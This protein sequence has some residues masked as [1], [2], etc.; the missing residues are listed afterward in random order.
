MGI[1]DKLKKNK[2]SRNTEKLKNSKKNF[3]YLDK[4]I[5]LGPKKVDLDSSVTI[6]DMEIRFIQGIK[7]DVDDLVID[8]HGYTIDSRDKAPIFNITGKNITIKNLSFINGYSQFNGGAVLVQEGASCKFE[9]CRFRNNSA[10]QHAGALINLGEIKLI[11]CIFHKNNSDNGGAILNTPQGIIDAND[12]FFEYNSATNGGAIGNFGK[13]A[14]YDCSF[15]RNSANNEGGAINSQSGILDINKTDFNENSAGTSGGAI[16]NYGKLDLIDSNLI[17]N[18]SDAYAGALDCQSGNKVRISKSKFINNSANEKACVI[19]NECEDIRLN[20]CEFL[21]NDSPNT[22]IVYNKKNSI[23]FFDSIFMDNKASSIIW[24][25]DNSKLVVSGGEFKNNKNSES[26]IYNN[27]KSCSISRSVFEGNMGKDAT[28]FMDI[29]NKTNLTLDDPKFN[30]INCIINDGTIDVSNM[31]PGEFKKFVQSN[32]GTIEFLDIGDY[33][34]STEETEAIV[35]KEIEESVEEDNETMSILDF[36]TLDDKIHSNLNN[37]ILYLDSN[38]LLNKRELKFFEG[39]IDLDID[40]LTIDGNNKIIDANNLSRIFNVIGKEITL[41]NIIFRNGSLKNDFD[42]HT[43]GGGAIRVVKDSKLNLENCKFIDNTS[44]SDGGAILNSGILESVT[45]QYENNESEYYGGVIYNRNS[46]T[47]KNDVFNSNSSY[48]GGAIY[49]NETLIIEDNIKLNANDNPLNEI[50]NVNS[51]FINFD[52]EELINKIFN[53][54]FINNKP[55]KDFK[56]FSYLNE[57]IQNNQEIELE[58]N[59]VFD[60]EEDNHFKD[61]IDINRNLIINGNGHSIDGNNIAALFRINDANVVLKNITF[62]RMRAY[63]NSIIE[64]N[65]SLTLENCKFNCNKC[66]LTNNLIK[67]NESLKIVNSKFYNNIAKD[68]SL[69][70]NESEMDI[71]GSSF[72]NNISNSRGGTI[73][74]LK[75]TNINN[76]EF[77]NN[78]SNMEGGSIT[79]QNF[80]VLKLDNVR[81]FNNMSKTRGGAIFSV[82]NIKLRFS[83]FNNNIAKGIGGAILSGRDLDV[84]HTQFFNNLAVDSGGAIYNSGMLNVYD[85]YFENNISEGQGGAITIFD[86]KL[87]VKKSSFFYNKAKE[88]G[89]IAISINAKSNITSCNFK[90]NEH[91]IFEKKKPNDY[92]DSQ[93]KLISNMGD[94]SKD[95]KA[96]KELIKNDP[97]YDIKAAALI[98]YLPHGQYINAVQMMNI[99]LNEIGLSQEEAIKLIET[100]ASHVELIEKQMK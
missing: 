74:N 57:E 28:N 85:S 80:A 4:L 36:T 56:S 100:Y 52:S 68:G 83:T 6:G 16:I 95:K 51:L 38:F 12:V 71:T 29:H 48:I 18:K 32:H 84:D 35:D 20:N 64:N 90:G 10:K 78:V 87:S 75:K 41:R 97:D 69:I 22:N 49:N 19:Y 63:G 26:T 76:S 58:Y 65:S 44:D 9:N 14:F 17:M 72:I 60:L 96:L 21:D 99:L 34:E 33:E 91:S 66:E 25:N 2:E 30:N 82:G 55:K 77:R 46:F 43:N 23:E 27:G 40:N 50:Y 13:I 79:N 59:I 67:N 5:H 81:F 88:E 37:N 11:S 86:G 47:T 42:E 94:Y 61:G 62:K 45:S 3:K 70:S 39:G 93:D 53:T 8:G 31:N 98:N 15:L 24:N 1:W 92:A 7:V 54:G 73:S 89:A